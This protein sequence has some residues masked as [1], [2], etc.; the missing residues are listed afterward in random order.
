MNTN[1][2]EIT[3]LSVYIHERKMTH[4]IANTHTHQNP[5][6]CPEAVTVHKIFFV[7]M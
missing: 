1:T 4:K 7:M 5:H 2:R 6:R 3:R